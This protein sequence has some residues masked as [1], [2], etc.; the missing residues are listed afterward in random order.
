MIILIWFNK[1][2]LQASLKRS[3]SLTLDVALLQCGSSL[4][5]NAIV[6][7]A[8]YSVSLEMRGPVVVLNWQ[9]HR[10]TVDTNLLH[11]NVITFHCSEQMHYTT[12]T[13]TSLAQYAQI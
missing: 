1:D 8:V 3:V 6:S 4:V 5:S 7:T 13:L 10:P 9:V 12:Y 2:S 11:L